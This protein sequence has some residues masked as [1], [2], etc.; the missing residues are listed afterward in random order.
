M[1]VNSAN[2]GR[3]R[4]GMLGGLLC[5]AA[6]VSTFGSA[7]A[8]DLPFV[9]APPVMPDARLKGRKNV[10]E[11]WLPRPVASAIPMPPPQAVAP[12]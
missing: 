4:H 1:G 6:L 12:R 3:L 8:A 7:S 11:A 2:A 9:K 10:I 5:S